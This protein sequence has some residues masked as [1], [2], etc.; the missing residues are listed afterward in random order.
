MYIVV[1]K[2]Q[3]YHQQEFF[4]LHASTGIGIVVQKK[5]CIM[6]AIMFVKTIV[7]IEICLSD[8]YDKDQARTVQPKQ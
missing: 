5:T 7:M 4:K 2:C 6:I 8:D 3:Y 1:D